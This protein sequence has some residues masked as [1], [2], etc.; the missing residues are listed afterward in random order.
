MSTSF[1]PCSISIINL[2]IMLNTLL[3]PSCLLAEVTVDWL[4]FPSSLPETT[5][6]YKQA[7]LTSFVL[8][9]SLVSLVAWFAVVAHCLWEQ[10]ILVVN[11]LLLSS[12][13]IFIKVAF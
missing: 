4:L 9:F 5:D 8:L 10:L 6:L 12:E 7:E 3:M 13:S 1:L 2:D 11:I